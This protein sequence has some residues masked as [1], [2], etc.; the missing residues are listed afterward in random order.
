[1]FQKDIIKD[2]FLKLKNYCEAEKFKGWDPYDGLNSKLFQATPLKNSALARLVLIQTF[3]RSPINLRPLFG[4][5]KQ[6]NAK[7]I[8]LFLTGYCN[9]FKT[10]ERKPR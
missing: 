5:P 1:M 10:L 3:K 8:A 6:Y 4:V 2:S 9:L 7:G